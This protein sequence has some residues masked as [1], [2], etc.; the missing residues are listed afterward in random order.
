MAQNKRLTEA[1]AWWLLSKCSDTFSHYKHL[2]SLVPSRIFTTPIY[3]LA[4]YLQEQNRAKVIS[5]PPPI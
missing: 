3:F 4:V 2:M 5:D 1:L